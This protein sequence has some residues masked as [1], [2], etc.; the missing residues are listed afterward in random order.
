MTNPQGTS[1]E[2]EIEVRAEKHGV[3]ALR[4]VKRGEKDEADVRIDGSGGDW[5][6]PALFWKRIVKRGGKVRQPL[7]ERYVVVLTVEDFLDMQALLYTEGV[8]PTVWVQAKWAEQLSV[9][10]VLAGLKAWL[11]TKMEDL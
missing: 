1:W 11:S 7:G 9:T 2:T 5:Q 3:P 6:V 4:L 10:K 8:A